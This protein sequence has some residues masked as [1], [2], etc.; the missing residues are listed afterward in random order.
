MPNL[1]WLSQTWP[2]ALR[3]QEQ[4]FSGCTVPPDSNKTELGSTDQEASPSAGKN[5]GVLFVPCHT[6]ICVPTAMSGHVDI[7]KA[8]RCHLLW[9]MSSQQRSQKL[10]PGLLS[11]EVTTYLSVFDLFLTQW[12]MAILSKGCKSDNWMTQ[13]FLT[14]SLWG[15]LFLESKKNLLLICIFWQFMPRKDPLFA[16][17]LSQE[18]SVNSYLC[19]PLALLHSV[20]SFF[21]L[22]QSPSLF[23]YMV[24]DSISWNIDEVPLTYPSANVFGFW[25]FKVHHKDWL[26]Y[27]D[28]ADRQVYSV[29]TSL[30]RWLTFLLRSLTVTLTVTPT[31]MLFWIYLL[32]LSLAYFLQW[33]SFR[34]KILT[35]L[36][37]QFPLLLC[38][39]WNRMPC[40]IA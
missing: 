4:M 38:Q 13:L 35:M 23:L 10:F 7:S 32:L 34:W 21:C 27:C 26:T 11:C 17:D 18:S 15:V 40:F 19:F 36:L 39:V 12:I 8:S 14:F 3:I 30:L 22:Y 5:T 1:F 2:V 25:D 37:P 9:H 16:Q 31:V 6:W 29:I 20:S 28:G 33:L 24:F